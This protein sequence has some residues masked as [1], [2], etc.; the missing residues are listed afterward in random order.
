MQVDEYKRRLLDR[1]QEG[2]VY[3]KTKIQQYLGE[4]SDKCKEL[5]PIQLEKYN[6]YEFHDIKSKSEL[7]LKKIAKMARNYDMI[8]LIKSGELDETTD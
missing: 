8:N 5:I 3:E 1:L 7:I 6:E 4:I 2:N